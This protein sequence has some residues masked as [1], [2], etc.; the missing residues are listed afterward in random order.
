[1]GR[2]EAPGLNR[3]RGSLHSLRD[4]G[5]D[6][7]PALQALVGIMDSIDD[8]ALPLGASPRGRASLESRAPVFRSYSPDRAL[9]AGTSTR[10]SGFRRRSWTNGSSSLRDL[11]G[12]EG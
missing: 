12:A 11:A 10:R 2:A 7:E 6:V 5:S 8:A 4:C 1:M 9:S 3:R